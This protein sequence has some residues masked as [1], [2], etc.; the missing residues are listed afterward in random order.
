MTISVE[1][2]QLDPLLRATGGGQG[3]VN[4][5]DGWSPYPGADLTNKYDELVLQLFVSFLCSTM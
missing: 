1:Y 3:D 2:N 5:E 4:N